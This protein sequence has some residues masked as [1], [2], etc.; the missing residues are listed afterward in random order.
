MHYYIYLTHSLRQWLLSNSIAI[1]GSNHGSNK[2]HN[3]IM[4]STYI[5]SYKIFDDYFMTEQVV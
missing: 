4:A 5:W 1:G 2:E 3:L